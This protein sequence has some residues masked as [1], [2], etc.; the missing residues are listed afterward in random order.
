LSE[1]GFEASVTPDGDGFT[2][3]QDHCAIYDVARE[4]PEVC[5]YEAATF[6]QVLGGD[7][8]LSRRETLAGGSPACVCCVSPVRAS[9]RATRTTDDQFDDT[10]RVSGTPTLVSGRGEQP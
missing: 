2:L 4:H 10:T 7:V 1:A 3:V 6:S 9:G 5:A 8:R